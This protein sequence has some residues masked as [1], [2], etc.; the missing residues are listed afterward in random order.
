MVS[1]SLKVYCTNKDGNKDY[2]WGTSEYYT[3][4]S[5][6]NKRINSN[7]TVK[8]ESTYYLR[9]FSRNSK[10]SSSLWGGIKGLSD[11]GITADTATYISD[12]FSNTATNWLKQWRIWRSW[13]DQKDYSLTSAWDGNSLTPTSP[14]SA[15]WYNACAKACNGTY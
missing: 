2:F 13:Y 10:S 3:R 4:I 12:N 7:T 11:S 9:F 6:L 15:K 1:V 5:R 8:V 14:I